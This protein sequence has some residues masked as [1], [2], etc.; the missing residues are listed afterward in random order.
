MKNLRLGILGGGQLGRM[1][2]QA[3]L[4][5]N[6]HV[7]VLDPDENAPCRYLCEEFVHGDFKDYDTV[8]AFGKGCEV[9]TIEIEHVNV[10]ALFQLEKEGV[11]VYPTPASLKTIQDKGLQKEFFQQ[12][13][14]P[15]AEYRLLKDTAALEANLDFL[16]AFQKLR[17][18][19]YDG[20][21]VVRLSSA[22]DMPKAFQ[23]PTVLEKLV[24]FEREISVI[25]ARN[26]KGEVKAFPV[27]EQVMHPEHNLVDFL[28]APA[29]IAYKLQRLAIEIATHV[30]TSL[31]IVGLL[32]VEMFVT[33][34]GQ[35][36]VNE[37]APRPHNSGHHTMKA[38]ATS[39]FEQHLR[40]ILGLP[41][42][43]T[44]PHCPAVLLNLL[45]EA[46]YS[47][48]AVYEGLGETLQEPGVHLHLYG[49]KFT[50]PHRKMGH[51]TV[52][53]PT[54]DEVKQKAE[55]VKNILKIIA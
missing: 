19:G 32:A 46:G 44:E 38:N 5:F 45:G 37:V 53:A 36:L 20:N 2:I 25:C 29:Q 12:N 8:Y 17:R 48:Q 41:L 27:V 6:L 35:I 11:Q 3:G 43:D 24:P 49:K 40:A 39:Q 26:T 7:R 54:I 4:D 21:G 47:G 31:D 10:E 51:L 23:G 34:D 52:L 1:L 50:R 30:T 55:R 33:Q 14:I 22:S 16:P 13:S 15:T 9:L 42:G 28:L 18:G